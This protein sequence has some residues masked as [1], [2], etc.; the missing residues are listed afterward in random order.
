MAKKKDITGV[1]TKAQ[2]RKL[3]GIGRHAGLDE[4]KRAYRTIIKKNHPDLFE[5][6]PALKARAEE[7]IKKV[8]QAYKLLAADLTPQKKQKANS[9]IFKQKKPK[10]KKS[11]QKKSKMSASKKA[12]QSASQTTGTASQDTGQKQSDQPE[13]DQDNPGR[14]SS[15]T[16]TSF[17][18]LLSIF[19]EIVKA[20]DFRPKMPERQNQGGAL[21]PKQGV[22]RRKEFKDILEDVIKGQDTAQL[23][24]ERQRQIARLKRWVYIK[25]SG[26]NKEDVGPI[27]PVKPIK[28]VKGVGKID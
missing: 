23:E 5:F 18:D 2:S 16:R 1:I 17:K 3:L 11:K 24:R 15:K 4:L 7:H 22:R 9:N 10:Q 25:G 28:K 26:Y 13:S 27:T 6:D 14:D 19:V 8:N 20:T 12:E 21:N